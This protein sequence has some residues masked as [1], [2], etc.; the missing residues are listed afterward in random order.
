MIDG[1]LGNEPP[2]GEHLRSTGRRG[3]G[4]GVAFANT[5]PDAE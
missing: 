2:W 5:S 4:L 3:L 1:F